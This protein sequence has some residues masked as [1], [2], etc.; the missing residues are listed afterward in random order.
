[1]VVGALGGGLAIQLAA[2]QVVPGSR[3]VVAACC[4]HA[5]DARRVVDKETVGWGW[6]DRRGWQVEIGGIGLDGGA[7]VG[8]GGAISTSVT[9][10]YV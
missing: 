6:A 1:M 2:L 4:R 3:S 10:A 8:V 5:V 7:G 9:L